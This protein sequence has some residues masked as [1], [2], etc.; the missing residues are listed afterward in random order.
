M[1]E[2]QL[3]IEA[4]AKKLEEKRNAEQAEADAKKAARVEEHQKFYGTVWKNLATLIPK[5]VL[6]Y[7]RIEG[8]DVDSAPY[9]HPGCEVNVP[10]C[11]PIRFRLHIGYPDYSVNNSGFEVAKISYYAPVVDDGEIYEGEVSWIFD[12]QHLMASQDFEV[13]LAIAHERFVEFQNKEM[14]RAATLE[15]LKIACAPIDE[16]VLR[17]AYEV[18]RMLLHPSKNR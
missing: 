12:E 4:G 3:I 6:Q 5:A 9:Y 16:K 1:D 8:V 7:C 18:G 11:A 10:G 15:Q 13:A 14:D 17:L 2:I